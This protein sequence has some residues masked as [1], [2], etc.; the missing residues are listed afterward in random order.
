VFATPGVAQSQTGEMISGYIGSVTDKTY[1]VV[2]KTAHAGTITELTTIAEAGTCT[3]TGKI[4]T[5]ALGG[6]A[7][8]VSSSEVSQAH[9]SSNTF[10]AGDDI[11]LEIT[12][13]SACT[14]LSFTF[15]YTRVYA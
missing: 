13:S 6:T 14:G 11:Q 5:T 1:K 7:N 12:S 3:A 2:V 9:A 4:N 15:K 10:A 8:S